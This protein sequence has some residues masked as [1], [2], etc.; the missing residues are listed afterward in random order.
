MWTPY[1]K[2]WLSFRWN[3]LVAAQ[4]MLHHDGLGNSLACLSY[5]MGA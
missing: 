2:S 1:T 5:C 3:R 4:S